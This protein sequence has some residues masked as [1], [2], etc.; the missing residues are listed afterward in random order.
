[1]FEIKEYKQ[2]ME[3]SVEAFRHKLSGIR[4]GRAHSN[5]LDTVMV[6]VYGTKMPL[7]QCANIVVTDAQLL[8]VTPFDNNN[9]QAV[10]SAIRDDQSLGFNPTD[11]GRVVRVPVPAL[12]EERRKEIVKQTH[13]KVETAKISVRNIRQD[14]IKQIKKLKDAKT[15]TE[16]DAHRYEKDVQDLVDQTN[17]E[18]TDLFAAKEKELMTV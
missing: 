6:E 7:N 8:T 1:M 15:I 3:K 9:L 17:Q 2:E 18:I 5:M 10:A 12:T 14:A 11:D 16:D 4:T 13:E